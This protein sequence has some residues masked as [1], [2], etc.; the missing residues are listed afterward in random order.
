MRTILP[1]EF[2][3][4][5]MLLALVAFPGNVQAWGW[6]ECH[7]DVIIWDNDNYDL[8]LNRDDF[9]SGSQREQSFIDAANSIMAIPGIT[10]SIDVGRTSEG[11]HLG[12]HTSQVDFQSDD[13]P[14]GFISWTD[15]IRLCVWLGHWVGE[16]VEADISFSTRVTWVTSVPRSPSEY[17]NNEGRYYLQSVANHELGHALGLNHENRVLNNMFP[18]YPF[19]GP[20]GQLLEWKPHGDMAEGLRRMYGSV[21]QYPN[22]YLSNFHREQGDNGGLMNVPPNFVRAGDEVNYQYTLSN[23]GNVLVGDFGV[24]FWLSLDTTVSVSSGDRAIASATF[25][26]PAGSLGTFSNYLRIPADMSG[27]YYIGVTLDPLH[28]INE[29]NEID[30]DLVAWYK[31]EIY[32][33]DV[34]EPPGWLTASDALFTDRVSIAWQ[35]SID[36]GV[37]HRIYRKE[38]SL[39]SPDEL[40]SDDYSWLID[41]GNVSSFVDTTAQ[42]GEAYYYAVQR[43][44]G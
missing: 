12:D 13:V 16:I 43:V 27:Y 40:C 6:D 9:P 44:K 19:G 2:L 28:E 31:T 42:Y 35:P 3:L 15:Y 24:S 33:T 39:V 38:V 7:G 30:N 18:N 10:L 21:G 32:P 20:I 17:L 41:V 14:Y 36:P 4:P 37:S 11:A 23:Q 22:L 25:Y 34:T 29:P 1:L 26:S 8:K 5:S